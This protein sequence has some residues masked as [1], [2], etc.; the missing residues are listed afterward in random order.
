[1]N[2]KAIKIANFGDKYIEK[3]LNNGF[4]L[5][6]IKKDWWMG[7]QFFLSRSFYQGRRDTISMCVEEKAMDILKEFVKTNNNDATFLI[8]PNNFHKIK[9]ALS[10]VIGKNKIKRGKDIEMVISILDF[11]AN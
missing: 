5:N 2:S 7:L 6:Q 4:N 10:Q 3:H 8:N 9:N 1:M 11:V